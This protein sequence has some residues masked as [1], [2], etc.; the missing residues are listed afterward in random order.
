M[1]TVKD[2]AERLN[3]APSTVYSL[4]SQNK[5]RCYRIGLGRGTIRVS[6]DDL[7]VFL[8][9]TASG[10]ATDETMPA[11]ARTRQKLRHITVSRRA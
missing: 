8:A 10:V 3:I 5:L 7:S 9:G 2:V 11:A 6:E 1:L 4:L